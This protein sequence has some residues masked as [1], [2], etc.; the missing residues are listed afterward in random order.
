[1]PGQRLRPRSSRLASDTPEGSQTQLAPTAVKGKT[2]RSLAP[3]TKSTA[4]M[5]MSASHRMVRPLDD[6]ETTSLDTN[7]SRGP[8]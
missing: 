3:T 5:M 2:S 7:D 1:M 6:S 8:A 4:M